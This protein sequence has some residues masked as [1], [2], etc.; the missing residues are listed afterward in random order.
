[1][2]TANWHPRLSDKV[3]SFSGA[4]YLM[5]SN[6]S[7][8][9]EKDWNEV[10]SA[11]SASLMVD[12][13]LTSL[14]QNLDG[15]DWPIKGKDETPAKYVDLGYAEMKELLALKGHPNHADFLI[16][17]LKETQAFDAPFGEMAEHTQA[18][19]KRDNQLLKNMAKLGIPED[20]PIELTA[21]DT[22]TV[23]FCNMEKL[24]TL[25]EFAVFAQGMSQNVIVG[26]DFK[27]LLN[28]LS[29]IDENALI[30]LLPF[31]LGS[32]NLHLLESLVQ[33]SHVADQAVRA[34]RANKALAWFKEEHDALQQAVT[35]GTSLTRVLMVLGNP[36]AESAAAE[37][38]KTY[39]KG[40]PSDSG[41]KHGFLGSLFRRF[42]K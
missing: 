1:M 18:S 5:S 8:Y 28:A 19:A 2:I 12:T 31:R 37:M 10:R 29:H 6:T 14:A 34:D 38:L 35:T 33:I 41:S 25:G 42:K 39:G 7:K 15:P 30:D 32:T 17:I 4:H 24:S 26:G 36:A 20:F 40:I 3:A 11:F 23:E 27:K 21:L 9:S 22:G 13:A 16:S